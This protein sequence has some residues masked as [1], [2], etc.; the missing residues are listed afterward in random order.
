MPLV[1]TK[2]E[3]AILM[4]EVQPWSQGYQLWCHLKDHLFW[5]MLIYEVSIPYGW[6]L[7]FQGHRV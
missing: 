4:L 2:S 5:S 1:A 7:I 6:E 3:K